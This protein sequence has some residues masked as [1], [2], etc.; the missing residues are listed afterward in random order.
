MSLFL[1]TSVRQAAPAKEFCTARLPRQSCWPLG[2]H[3]IS[4]NRQR[5]LRAQ[6]RPSTSVPSSQASSPSPAVSQPA[7]QPASQISTTAPQPTSGSNATPISSA[8]TSSTP[9]I[10]APQT[11]QPVT[12]TRDNTR[13]AGTT[14]PAAATERISRPPA[15]SEPE[16]EPKKPALGEVHLASPTMNRAAAT[17]DDGAEAPSISSGNTDANAG[18][19]DSGLSAGSGKSPAAPEVPLPIGGDVKSARLIT[20]VAADLPGHG[21]KPARV[22]QCAHRCVDRRQRTRHD[23][24]SHFRTSAICNK[25]LWIAAASVEVSA[26]NP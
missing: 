4:C 6:E 8:S 14:I 7:S 10:R 25:P 2:A 17:Q 16:P 3:G 18:G 12:V 5:Q 20:S 1:P 15:Q 9:F 21:Q 23:H 22:W 19:M 26:G 11:Q 13:G 24:E